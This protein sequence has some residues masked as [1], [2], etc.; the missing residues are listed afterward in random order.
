MPKKEDNTY[1]V[2]VIPA[3]PKPELTADIQPAMEMPKD[4]LTE[5]TSKN[6][7]L[8]S[9]HL[10]RVF[11]ARKS[12]TGEI[13]FQDEALLEKFRKEFLGLPEK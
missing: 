4:T 10:F 7:P 8:E 1:E 13:N 9:Q 3:D 6:I 12:G 11:V 5:F 2:P